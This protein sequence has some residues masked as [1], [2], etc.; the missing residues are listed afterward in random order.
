MVVNGWDEGG[1]CARDA[2]RAFDLVVMF[3]GVWFWDDVCDVIVDVCVMCG[4]RERL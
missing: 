2:L 4:K 3:G 1:E